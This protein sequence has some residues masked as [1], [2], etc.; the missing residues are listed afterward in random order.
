MLALM[1]VVAGLI[2]VNEDRRENSKY[3]VYK[4]EKKL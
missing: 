3:I 1:P 4:M 2:I